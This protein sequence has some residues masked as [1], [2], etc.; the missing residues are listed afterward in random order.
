[1]NIFRFFIVSMVMTFTGL[2]AF[3]VS[4]HNP[5]AQK[6]FDQGLIYIFAYNH[7]FAYTNFKEASELDPNLA[8]AYWG[9]A[10][11]LG[12]NINQDVTPQNEKRA[13]AYSRISRLSPCVTQTIQ[14]QILCP[15]A[16]FTGMP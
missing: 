16:L 6:K 3:P 10:L 7:D 1:M 2:S 15:Y 13:F 11:A 12:Q 5:E 14:K 4:T 8:M 9:M